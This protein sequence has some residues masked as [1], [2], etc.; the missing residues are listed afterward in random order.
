LKISKF[1]YLIVFIKDFYVDLQKGRIRKMGIWG[2]FL[3]YV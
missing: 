1:I 2:N 3:I